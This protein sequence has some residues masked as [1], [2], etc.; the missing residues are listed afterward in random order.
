MM[1]DQD[2]QAT[3]AGETAGQNGEADQGAQDQLQTVARQPAG[4]AGTPSGDQA[5]A[6]AGV[7]AGNGLITPYD[8]RPASALPL[9]AGQ[10]RFI[11]EWFVDFNAKAAAIRAGYSSRTARVIGPRLVSHSVIAAVIAELL[12]ERLGMSRPM[13]LTAFA[14]LAGKRSSTASD[15]IAA[16]DKLAKASGLYRDQPQSAAQINVH[17]YPG[18]ADL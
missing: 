11:Q 10:W 7:T 8:K 12:P 18:E 15:Q 4:T 16:L 13:I 2:N 6:L 9:N 14:K 3:V 1:A 17:I 5:S